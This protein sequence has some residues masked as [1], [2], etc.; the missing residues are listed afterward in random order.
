MRM[1]MGWPVPHWRKA[2]RREQTQI[3]MAQS[4]A[5][6]R[7]HRAFADAG[8]PRPQLRSDLPPVHWRGWWQG[9]ARGKQG[10]PRQQRGRAFAGRAGVGDEKKESVTPHFTK[11]RQAGIRGV[12]EQMIM[13]NQ[14][15]LDGAHLGRRL[16]LNSLILALHEDG[17]SCAQ[18]AREL[19]WTKPKT[20]RRL[21]SL[22]IPTGHATRATK[23]L[24]PDIAYRIQ[25][26]VGHGSPLLEVRF[27][28]LEP[29][30]A[31]RS[32]YK[33]YSADPPQEVEL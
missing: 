29:D 1:L 20:K 6:P 16:A 13:F 22:G 7:L 33:L 11:K 32:W 8:L 18:I 31:T 15:R 9:R 17:C 23:K 5:R 14:T 3:R 4:K 10:T 24:G 2:V 21:I 25:V 26:S 27:G 19:G 30:W 28:I 12:E